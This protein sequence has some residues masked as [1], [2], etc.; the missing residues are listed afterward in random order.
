MHPLSPWLDKALAGT[1]FWRK[2]SGWVVGVGVG[3]GPKTVEAVS[4]KGL[5]EGHTL[6]TPCPCTASPWGR[7]TV[8]LQ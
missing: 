6:Y 3:P 5:K 7:H 4:A 8:H 2:V 1:Y